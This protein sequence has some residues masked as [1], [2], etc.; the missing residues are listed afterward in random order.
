MTGHDLAL[1]THSAD[2]G[3]LARAHPTAPTVAPS[4]VLVVRLPADEGLVYFDNPHQ[5]AEVLIGETGPDPVAHIPSGLIGAET[6]VPLH[7]KG[8]DAFLG[9]QH[10]VDD[11]EPLAQGLVGVLEDR[12][13]DMREAVALGGALVALP[14][15]GAAFQLIDL[16][17]A[18]AGATD[19]YGPAVPY[20]IGAAGILIGKR[21]L[22]LGDRH[23]V[24]TLLGLGHGP[25]PSILEAA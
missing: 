25:S 4:A 2:N 8:T 19:P 17:R 7:L 24:D 6:H 13:G 1:A 10:Q 20:Q 21:R 16:L 11:A 14:V 23:L 22:P 18:A 5:L 3:R 9:R 15:P 12:P